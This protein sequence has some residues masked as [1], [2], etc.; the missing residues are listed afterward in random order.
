MVKSRSVG[1]KINT[2]YS[3][4][5]PSPG[6]I[7]GTVL[8][9]VIRLLLSRQ[10]L[11]SSLPIYSCTWTAGTL[12]YGWKV[13]KQLAPVSSKGWLIS[14]MALTEGNRNSAGQMKL[15]LTRHQTDKTISV[16]CYSAI[17]T[18]LLQHLSVTRQMTGYSQKGHST[19]GGWQWAR[20]SPKFHLVS[21]L[22]NDNYNNL[23]L[24]KLI[25][26]K[27]HTDKTNSFGYN[28]SIN[29]S[30]H[31]FEDLHVF[32]NMAVNRWVIHSQTDAHGI[33]LGNPHIT[34]SPR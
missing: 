21:P 28:L 31:F 11:P 34:S 12:A 2:A 18:G 3:E 8:V 14:P 30:R 22:H 20:Q 17:L 9:R 29:N 24:A 23:R 32:L 25:F 19:L 5:F 13:R 7:Q 4:G 15:T 6:T 27:F 33:T 16:Q 1:I 10:L 26:M